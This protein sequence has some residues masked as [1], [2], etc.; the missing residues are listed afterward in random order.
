VRFVNFIFIFQ[1]SHGVHPS[2]TGDFVFNKIICRP[3]WCFSCVFESYFCVRSS[4]QKNL[5]KSKNFLQT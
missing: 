3:M 1:F 4:Y 5:Q 2:L